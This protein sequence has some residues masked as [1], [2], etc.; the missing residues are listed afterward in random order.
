MNKKK[1][2]GKIIVNDIEGEAIRKHDCYTL[3][4]SIGIQFQKR[5]DRGE[6]PKLHSTFS[7]LTN[8]QE[9]LEKNPIKPR[10]TVCF[11]EDFHP[12]TVMILDP[13]DRGFFNSY[14]MCLTTHLAMYDG[15]FSSSPTY[16]GLRF[17]LGKFNSE[18]EAL[19]ACQRWKIGI[20][21]NHVKLRLLVPVLMNG[22]E[23][24]KARL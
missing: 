19:I 15:K 11:V 14:Q 6:N 24:L 22:L 20:A 21:K 2:I 18:T 17:K 16:C 12:E 5:V 4:L 1:M 13:F 23:E 3:A 9:W 10:H 8:I 7:S